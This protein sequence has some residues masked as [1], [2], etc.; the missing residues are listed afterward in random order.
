[1]KDKAGNTAEVRHSF[2]VAENAFWDDFRAPCFLSELR[3]VRV[4][5]GIR[6]KRIYPL[7]I[8]P[9]KDA[10]IS[11][12][13]SWQSGH[14]WLEIGSHDRL[15]IV[16]EFRMPES[17]DWKGKA[18]L[19]LRTFK[20][21]TPEQSMLYRVYL[22]EDDFE[23]DDLRWELKHSR[24]WI[25]EFKAEGDLKGK[26]VRIPLS[27]DISQGGIIRLMLAPAS[28][29]YRSERFYSRESLFPPYLELTPEPGVVVSDWI[30][31]PEGSRWRAFRYDATVPKGASVRISLLGEEGQVLVKKL[32]DGHDLSGV[33]GKKVKLRAVLKAN[34]NGESPVL[35]KWRLT[36]R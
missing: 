18:S 33:G 16:T 24:Q 6:L 3:N 15:R 26:E 19:V 10:T 20:T 28:R 17:L 34:E 14:G 1:L 11:P 8:K 25:G 13:G 22:L 29:N 27:L 36:W 30:E 4:A 2:R 9:A 12:I 5:D 21:G 31:L 32:K 7:R 23:E 35:R